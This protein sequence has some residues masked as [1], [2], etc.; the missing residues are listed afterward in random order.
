VI[1]GFLTPEMVAQALA[2]SG[3]P[4]FLF[5]ALVI[6]LVIVGGFL[7]LNAIITVMILGGA[8]PDPAAFGVSPVIL[9]VAYLAAWGLTVGSSP[10]AMSTLIIGNLNQRSG[11]TVGFIWNG[12]YTL[13]GYLA[14]S[15]V[16]GIAVSGG[17]FM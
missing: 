13:S 9:A 3:T 4:A 17:A 7:G 16:L 1:A 11:A 2:W 6:A 8:L 12:W 14:A 10:V 15:L 5:P